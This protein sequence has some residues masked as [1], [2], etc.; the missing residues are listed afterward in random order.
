MVASASRFCAVLFCIAFSTA[1]TQE[2]PKCADDKTLGLVKSIIVEKVGVS[3]TANRQNA[4]SALKL[5]YP[6]ASGFDE[7]IKKYTCE[8]KLSADS[9]DLSV[10]YESQ[11]DDKNVHLVAVS[12]SGLDLA[13]L[14]AALLKATPA[15]LAE[16]PGA[17]AQVSIPAPVPPTPEPRST[18]DRSENPLKVPAPSFNCA[19]AATFVEREICGDALLAR[20]DAAMAENYSMMLSS[21][22][23]DGA[24]KELERSQRQWLMQRNKCPTRDCLAAEYRGRVDAVCDY[25]VLSG[26]HPVCVEADAIK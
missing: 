16:E 17:L 14:Q 2:V 19:R 23:G 15:A 4:K 13:A 24:R 20:L 12:L 1:C 25:P 21:N 8:A 9:V 5:D 6:R 26:V 22:I 7:K 3:G 11:L 18:S 10:T